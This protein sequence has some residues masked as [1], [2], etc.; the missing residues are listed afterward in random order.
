MTEMTFLEQSVTF[1]QSFNLIYL[2]KFVLDVD[3]DL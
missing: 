3:F 2:N 1:K